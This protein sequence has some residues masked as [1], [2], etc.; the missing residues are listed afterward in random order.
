MRRCFFPRDARLSR[1]SAR[2]LHQLALHL[3]GRAE[4]EKALFLRQR[5]AGGAQQM[6]RLLSG[7]LAH[8]FPGKLSFFIRIRC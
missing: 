6:P 1:N 4:R 2:L 7:S 8:I 3:T 5:T